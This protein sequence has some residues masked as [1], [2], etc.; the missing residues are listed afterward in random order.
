MK[1][2]NIN[3]NDLNY[4][5][6]SL[7][8]LPYEQITSNLIEINE[9]YRILP[10]SSPYPGKFRFSRIPHMYEPALMLSPQSPVER[11][12]I[13]KSAQGAGTSG[14]S[15]A[16]ILFKILSDPG[17]VLAMV[18]SLEFIQKWDEGRLGPLIELSGAK[19]KL[20]SAYTKSSQHGGKGDAMGRK[21]WPGGRL[22]IISF[23][24]VNLLRNTSYQDVIIEEE[25][26]INNTSQK[27]E[28]QGD[29]VDVAEMRTNAFAGR[30]KILN[31]STPLIL[32]SSLIYQNFLLGDQRRYHI[33]CPK[34]GT[35]QILT[36]DHLKFDKDKH[37]NVIKNSVRYECQG[38]G[39]SETFVNEQKPELLL[40]EEL[41]GTAKWVPMN[42]EAAK[43]LTVSY[44]FSAMI[45]PVGFNSWYDMAQKFVDIN[46]DPERTQTFYNLWKGEP[47]SDYS[48][49]PPSETL[50][51]L[52]GTYKKG[53]LP[54]E[55]EGS[56]IIA[57]LGC[58]IQAGNK[59]EGQYLNGKEPRIEAS[60]YGFGLNRRM[61]L[62]D[63]YIIK[64]DVTDYRSGAFATLRSMIEN[65]VF[66][67]MPMKIFIDSGFQTDEVR[68]FCDRSNNIFPIKGESSIK[69]GYFNRIELQGFRSADGSPLA[70]YELNTNP[71]KR[72]IYNAFLLR[73]DPNTK[74]YPD[75]YIMFPIDLESE[76]LDQI[77]SERPKPKVKNGKIVGY[78]WEAHGANEAL[79]C[80][81]YAIEALEAYIF[82]VSQLAGEE[83]SNYTKFWEFAEKKFGRQIGMVKK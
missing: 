4:M 59:R 19:E 31:I 70:M 46:G 25:D 78:E 67:I 64:G 73:Q 11:I 9:K 14:T 45:N 49:A 35:L 22:D 12:H 10:A 5:I 20:R 43:P 57:M 30:R 32:Q 34:C 23:G 66:P 65:K 60:L 28:T 82:E 1:N 37:G 24:Q 2:E 41:G 50:H 80:T 69:K 47:F 71:I 26:E 52:K 74:M 62:I 21:T 15:E 42:A 75:G 3:E 40:C 53:T 8:E 17:P 63:H 39:C 68:K 48:D 7:D 38:K 55:S 77:T 18:P 61:W 81:A 27:G 16:L 72:R 33:R 6:K 58:D 76:Y 51:L 79:D 13:M 36:F 83:A 54:N 56:P 29:L 44:H